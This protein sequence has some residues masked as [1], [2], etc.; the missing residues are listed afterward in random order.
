MPFE[1]SLNQ[2]QKQVQR[3]A[4]NQQMQQSLKVLRYGIE[5]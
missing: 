1:A 2:T 5:D 4:M 3:L